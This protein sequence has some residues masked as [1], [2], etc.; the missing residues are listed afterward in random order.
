MDLS[1]AETL[2]DIATQAWNLFGQIDVLINNGGISCIII[3]AA[4]EVTEGLLRRMMEVD[5]LWT[6]Y[7]DTIHP[8]SYGEQKYLCIKIVIVDFNVCRHGHAQVRP[9]REYF[10]S[11]W[12][13]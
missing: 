12:K 9:D 13:D 5:F 10:I 7:I 4:E 11:C 3:I 2:P 6:G 1:K 8:T